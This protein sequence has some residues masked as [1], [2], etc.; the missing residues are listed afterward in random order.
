MRRGARLSLARRM[1]AVFYR[2]RLLD[3]TLDLHDTLLLS[4]FPHLSQALWRGYPP[5]TPVR[6]RR[7]A[8]T[9]RAQLKWAV[10]YYRLLVASNYESDTLA[11]YQQAQQRE[12]RAKRLRYGTRAVEAPLLV[13]ESEALYAMC[14]ALS[15]IG[16][17]LLQ[18][19][20]LDEAHVRLDIAA[21]PLL[22]VVAAPLYEGGLL[23]DPR[24]R[25]AQERERQGR[26]ALGEDFRRLVVPMHICPISGNENRSPEHAGVLL[27]KPDGALWTNDRADPLGVLSQ[28][29]TGSF[30]VMFTSAS[31]FHVLLLLRNGHLWAFGDN[32]WN[33]LG[34]AD[35]DVTT[36][37]VAEGVIAAACGDYHTM[38][39]KRDG[40]LWG[41]GR[42][43]KGT[44]GLGDERQ[45]T[46]PVRVMEGGVLSVAC[47]TYRSAI[48]K[49]DGS[50]W[51]AG[52]DGENHL[53]FVR[54]VADGVKMVAC[55]NE[56]TVFIR[57]DATLWG[58][59]VDEQAQL[60]GFDMYPRYTIPIRISERVESVACGHDHTVI[61]L[62]SGEVYATGPQWNLDAFLA[63]NV[64]AV[65]CGGDNTFLLRS[66]GTLLHD[67]AEHGARFERFDSV[68]GYHALT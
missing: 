13:E 29:T 59:G 14:R 45:R 49:R 66:D 12:Y 42:N 58:F 3:G 27:V 23:V 53:S 46:T 63:D 1:E 48:I 51:S 28:L 35:V 41:C 7:L 55:G 24:Y 2:L 64:I 9:T 11:L 6:L 43:W 67:Y 54:V 4:Y 62:T 47:S 22:A 60:G 68:T 15:L 38:F 65:A 50:L 16:T 10:D 19:L 8:N 31:E 25:W 5:D 20:C 30:G 18:A 39:V 37:L 26:A 44:L 34:T 57:N 56:H 61:L 17:P 32:E 52:Q 33:Q 40:S 36:H 21:R